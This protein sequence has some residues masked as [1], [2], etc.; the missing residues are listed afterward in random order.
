M[1]KEQSGPR[2]ESAK[3]AERKSPKINQEKSSQVTREKGQPVVATEKVMTQTEN[4]GFQAGR[5]GSQEGPERR[6]TEKEGC[7]AGQ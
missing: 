2:E 7:H 5:V 6:G 4:K 3:G 1:E